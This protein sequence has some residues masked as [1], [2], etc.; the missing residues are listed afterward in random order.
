MHVEFGEPITVPVPEGVTRTAAIGAAAD[1]L[2]DALMAHVAD[3]SARTGIR[4]PAG[5]P[6]DGGPED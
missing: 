3:V 5:G 4:L 2:R 6:D 1:L